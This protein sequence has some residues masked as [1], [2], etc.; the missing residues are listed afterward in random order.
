MLCYDVR[1][2]KRL[3]K[4]YKMMNGYGDP[5]QYSVFLCDLSD[6]EMVY[7]KRDLT[8]LLNLNEDRVI[9]V[10]TGKGDKIQTMGEPL[11]HSRESAIIV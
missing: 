10:N 7:M 2:P 9:I 5:V 11:K 3:N 4:V 6:T 1:D 8:E